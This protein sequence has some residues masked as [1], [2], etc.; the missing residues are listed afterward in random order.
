MKSITFET[1][2]ER[3]TEASSSST[4]IDKITGT[5]KIQD[6]D[7]YWIYLYLFYFDC[8][9]FIEEPYSLNDIMYVFV[10]DSLEESL[11]LE[12]FTLKYFQDHFLNF[13]KY[14]YWDTSSAGKTW[15]LLAYHHHLELHNERMLLKFLTVLETV[16]L[17]IFDD[18]FENFC[19]VSGYS[20]INRDWHQEELI[21]LLEQKVSALLD[22]CDRLRNPIQTIEDDLPF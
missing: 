8:S 10:Y 5:I 18:M 9:W 12:Y 2:I 15:W 19:I 21:S 17:N 4:M 22:E 14:I 11:S 7:G 20:S 6:E 3:M 16:G 13:S 1:L